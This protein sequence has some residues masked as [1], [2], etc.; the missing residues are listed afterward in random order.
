MAKTKYSDEACAIIL[1]HHT[2]KNLNR[3][4]SSEIARIY[5]DYADYSRSFKEIGRGFNDGEQYKKYLTLAHNDSKSIYTRLQPQT[6]FE[7]NLYLK[8]VLMYL[9]QFPGVSLPDAIADAKNALKFGPPK[10]YSDY[11]PA[12]TATSEELV[13]GLKFMKCLV[14]SVY[15][16]PPEK[17]RINESSA[18]I[19]ERINL[20]CARELS[21]AGKKQAKLSAKAQGV[22]T[23]TLGGT[24]LISPFSLDNLAVDSSTR[25]AVKPT[26]RGE[27]E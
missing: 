16:I 11:A 12:R 10:F 21:K 13:R 2:I 1:M 25:P 6:L 27:E 3:Q 4:L 19:N 14:S 15:N 7:Y 26:E 9:Q 5:G 17:V 24:E 23:Q 8:H 20:E 18:V 22:A